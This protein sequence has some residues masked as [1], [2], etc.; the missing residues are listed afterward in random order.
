M[1]Y[2]ITL[3]QESVSIWLDTSLKKF[4]VHNVKKK[5]ELNVSNYNTKHLSYFSLIFSFDKC[6]YFS[7]VDSE[8]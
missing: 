2:N 6:I 5:L 8:E 4:D 1:H 3:S 7:V